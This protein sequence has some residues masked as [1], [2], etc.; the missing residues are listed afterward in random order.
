MT[1]F[2]MTGSIGPADAI[3]VAARMARR[4]TAIGLILAAYPAAAATPLAISE[5]PTVLGSAPSSIV[6][7]S[8]AD[9]AYFADFTNGKI[10]IGLYSTDLKIIEDSGPLAP[11]GNAAI[12]VA[13]G[14]AP[15]APGGHP[16]LWVTISGATP[17]VV[18]VDASTG[19]AT[20]LFP[21]G[22]AYEAPGLIALGP[23]GNLWFPIEP[24]H[25]SPCSPAPV[26]AIGRITPDGDLSLA[27]TGLVAGSAP[28]G[29]AA[30]PDGAL[31]FTDPNAVAPAIGR[32]TTGAEPK[33]IEFTNAQSPGLRA[34]SVPVA[35]A[36]DAEGRLWFTDQSSVAPAIGR[37][38]PAA[39]EGNPP[40]I[41]EF[42][43]P[44]A[45]SVPINIAL[46]PDGNLWFTDPGCPSC[47]NPTPPAIGRITLDGTSLA[48]FPIAEFSGGAVGA[49]HPEGITGSGP[50]G[51]GSV[52]Y[53]DSLG[54]IGQVTIPTDTLTVT[55]NGLAGAAHRAADIVTSTQA[56]G[57]T[58]MLA[59]AKI[60]CDQGGSACAAAFPDTTRV[61]LTAT[62]AVGERFTG[63]SGAGAAAGG[64]S[65]ALVC[66][67]PLAGNLD[68]TITASFTAD[69]ALPPPA[70]SVLS[71]NA[72]GSL[73][74][75]V[76]NSSTGDAC[77]S[78]C[79]AER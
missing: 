31:W 76:A 78:A 56:P 23:D 69:A 52:F 66:A 9:L 58:G 33:I 5:V 29:I 63:W 16:S 13:V 12:G 41:V 71:S 65:T 48:E 3:A 51:P 44:F 70:T 35:I 25:C 67:V 77:G 22:N 20:R 68:S 34:T 53:A 2:L 79:S 28:L 75:A 17:G 74:R 14:P 62:P 49:S 18:E 27:T 64:C 1:L 43:L 42:P 38:T 10:G 11:G 36:A 60:L 24:R 73:I 47:E 7:S 19:S 15:V 45:S 37:I 59:H 57:V 72:A 40:E 50:G 30:G 39:V 21:L 55:V 46:G 32:V 8:S 4:A 6:A 61:T 54:A 26:A